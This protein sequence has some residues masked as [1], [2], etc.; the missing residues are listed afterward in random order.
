MSYL[1]ER[2][3]YGVRTFDGRE[4]PEHWRFF[5]WAYSLLGMDT[6]QIGYVE[7][8]R[9]DRKSHMGKELL[10]IWQ[11]GDPPNGEYDITSYNKK[12]FIDNFKGINHS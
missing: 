10:V 6:V 2:N 5:S 1:E 9:N 12:R 7:Q 3:E 8:L 11:Q 4:Y